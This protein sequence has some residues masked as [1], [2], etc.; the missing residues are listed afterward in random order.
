MPDPD[1][2]T[3]RITGRVLEVSDVFVGGVEHCRRDAAGITEE[4]A[5]G[6][7]LRRGA[8]EAAERAGAQGLV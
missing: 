7:H 6:R 1:S 3:A 8:L 2:T 4:E 5:V